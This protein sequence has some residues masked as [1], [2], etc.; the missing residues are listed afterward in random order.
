MVRINRYKDKNEIALGLAELVIKHQDAAL[1]T[2]EHF[3]IGISGGSLIELLKEG[4]VDNE[5]IR[6]DKWII[7]FCDERIVPLNDKE[8]NFGLFEEKILKKLIGKVKVGPEVVT[9]NESLIHQQDTSNDEHIATEYAKELPIDGL[10]IALLGCGPDGHTC[11][12]FPGEDKG[13]VSDSFVVAIDN[14]P[15]PPPRRIT[16]TLAYLRR[17][18]ALCFVASGESKKPIVENVFAGYNGGS[19]EDNAVKDGCSLPCGVVSKLNVGG[20][21]CWLIDY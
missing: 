12:I 20:G 11:S 15:K 3:T 21:V 17:C 5:D 19:S 14:S 1:S 10:D 2:K 18:H 7:Y 13:I 9:I 4:L 8:S 16:F 6:W